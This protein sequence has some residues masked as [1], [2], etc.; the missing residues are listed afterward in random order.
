MTHD[1]AL[2]ITDVLADRLEI[3]RVRRD[4]E[5]RGIPRPSASPV[6]AV[7]PMRKR[8]YGRDV[9]PDVFPDEAV[10]E[11]P[12]TKKSP[13]PPLGVPVVP[14]SDKQTRTV[15][16]HCERMVLALGPYR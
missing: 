3:V 12:V 14:G 13:Y 11:D 2:R 1:D 5:T 7:M 10:A 8:H 9:V 16:G 4:V 6:T 15:L